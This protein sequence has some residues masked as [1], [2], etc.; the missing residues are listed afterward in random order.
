ME[1]ITQEIS[2]TNSSSTDL[3]ITFLS[4]CDCLSIDPQS[5]TISAG[6]RSLFNLTLE[7]E[8]YGVMSRHMLV[9]KNGKKTT[10][11]VFVTLPDPPKETLSMGCPECREKEKAIEDQERAKKI[12]DSWIIADIYYSPGCSTCEEFIMDAGVEY[13]INKHNILEKEELASLE[14]KLN[15][16]NIGL[17]EF[18][19][20]I[21]KD[22]VLQGGEVNIEKF[23]EILSF[24]QETTLNEKYRN[25]VEYLKPLPIF[26]AGLLDGVNP[27]AF[28]TLLFLISSLFYVGRG[29][30]EILTVGIIF[31]IT[32]FLSYYLVGLGLLNVIR[33]AFIFPIISK[34]IKYILI[35]ALLIL[36]LLSFFDAYKAKKGSVNQ[37]KLQLPKGIKKR[38]HSVIRENTR[39]RGLVVGTIIIGIMVTIFELTCT[40]QVYLP[41]ISYIIKIEASLSSYFYLTL[42]NLGFIIPLVLVFATIYKGSN[43]K[44]IATWF[45]SRLYI[46]KLLLGLLFVSMIFFI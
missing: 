46:I 18:P 38:I 36:S 34:V 19:L 30:K 16:L 7:P 25:T 44:K 15:L 21:Y 41:I 17:K 39:N 13:T 33:T 31:T 20:L 26:F 35:I 8:G 1:V 23:K 37:M 29:R 27:C 22:R 9:D 24:K 2:V 40:G 4:L 32:I 3:E 10:T 5:R 43:N 28:T 14:K 12:L 6:E 42:Y 11:K 45:S